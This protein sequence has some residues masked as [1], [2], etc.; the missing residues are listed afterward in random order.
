MFKNPKIAK[1][2]KTINKALF[3]LNKELFNEIITAENMVQTQ[4][5][6]IFQE[7][8]DTVAKIQKY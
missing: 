4:C 6:S 7:Y 3:D 8:R 5:Y 1:A 2:R